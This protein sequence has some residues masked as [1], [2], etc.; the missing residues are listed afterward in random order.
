MRIPTTST[1][2][3]VLTAIRIISTAVKNYLPMVPRPYG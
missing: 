3:I 2:A 1:A